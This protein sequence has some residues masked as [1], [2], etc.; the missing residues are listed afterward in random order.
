LRAAVGLLVFALWAPVR[1][2]AGTDGPAA[3]ATL[4]QAGSPQGAGGPGASLRRPRSEQ[5]GA[6]EHF[7]RI[8][9][10]RVQT[11]GSQAGFATGDD[12]F[13]ATRTSEEVTD[14]VKREAF[15][16]GLS[17]GGR[18]DPVRLSR[19]RHWE[20]LGPKDVGGRTRALVIDRDEPSRMWAGSVAG[21]VWASTDGGLSW[22]PDDAGL[23]AFAISCLAID[24]ESKALFAGTGE[25][26]GDGRTSGGRGMPQGVQGGGVFRKDGGRWT[27]MPGTKVPEFQFVNRLALTR[28]KRGRTVLLAATHRGVFRHL[29]ARPAHWRKAGDGAFADVDFH[30]A[31]PAE[32]V[33]GSFDM[34]ASNAYYSRDGG[35][36]WRQAEHDGWRWKGR[37]ELAYARANPAIVYASVSASRDGTAFAG[38]VFQSRDGGRSYAAMATTCPTSAPGKRFDYM[39]GAGNYRNTIW[40][41]DP[42]DP[43]L[44]I[45]G[46][47]NVYRSRDGGKTLEQISEDS[48]DA[49]T[50]ADHHVIVEHPRYGQGGCRIAFF[51]CDG[52]I[53]KAADLTT[54]GAAP[55][56]K[57]GWQA[58]DGGYG[59]V[60]F[61]GACGIDR[62]KTILGGA[63][64]NDARLL[65]SRGK[66]A[67]T[68]SC[69]YVG[70][71][72]LCAAD[73]TDPVVQRLYT[74]G[75]Y[76]ALVRIRIPVPGEMPVKEPIN[77]NIDQDQW[78]CPGY[79]IED[80][81]AR[82]TNFIAPFVLDPNRPDRLL[83]GGVSLWR[84]SNVREPNDPGNPTRSGP[85]WQSIKDP[86]VSGPHSQ[87]APISAVAIAAGN[88]DIVWVG[89]N[90]GRL[91][92]TSN[93]TSASPRWEPMDI[94]AAR[95]RYCTRIFIDPREPAQVYVMFGG[96]HEDNLW[97]MKKGDRRWTY[98][99]VQAPA[100][101]HAEPLAAPLRCLTIHPDH[102]DLLYLGTEVGLYCSKDSGLCW[103][104]VNEGPALCP[105][106]DLFWM[107][108]TLVA[109][110]HA[111]GLYRVDLRTIKY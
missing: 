51:G 109:A 81:K 60:Q 34:A 94:P 15:V 37:V 57:G 97:V 29:S 84:T 19:P 49:L 9:Q 69:I 103:L 52:G 101:P 107:D 98:L 83:A 73:G 16:A 38:R 13:R 8:E 86:I 25:Y 93:G 21:G 105:V 108:R 70:D 48:E 22:I 39:D 1:A 14:S 50:H 63:Q 36:H 99:K 43:A 87:P 17:V 59:T 102:P 47:T 85:R 3:P 45:V 82:R 11:E 2:V 27:R 88:S 76:M 111:R 55:S 71:G 33:A 54:V 92:R 66:A 28:D 30:P 100:Q 79:R 24:P 89:H 20:W 40:A 53:Y 12:L 91:F 31:K 74:E 46:G 77:G 35:R 75:P 7:A 5:D 44:V 72:G 110:T 26:I 90:N 58:M 56:H 41:S 32:A 61:N 6:E 42:C 106:D 4:P 67:A 64:D 62:T 96:Y 68:W 23:A 10:R 104:P 65:S 18:V 80:A 78:K 95:G